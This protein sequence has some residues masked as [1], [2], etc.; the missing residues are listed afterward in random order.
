MIHPVPPTACYAYAMKRIFFLVPVIVIAA[1]GFFVFRSQGSSYETATVT[2]GAI[3]QEV[4]ASGNVASPDTIDL[5][6][7]GSGRL[8]YLPVKVGDHVSAGATLARLDT[9]VM[10]AQRAQAQAAAA[11]QQAQLGS[12]QDGTRPEQLAVTEAQVDSDQTALAQANQAIINAIQNAYTQSDDAVHNKTDQFFSNP[13][14]FNPLVTFSSSNVQL[15]TNVQSERAAAEA[16]LANWQVDLAH[17]SAI[18]PAPAVLEAEANLAA[19]MQLVSDAN[20]LLNSAISNNQQASATTIAGWIASVATA[21]ANVNA[22][23]TTLTSAVTAQKAAAAALDRDKKNLSLEQAGSTE[24][25]LDAQ[26]ALVQQAQASVA[27][28]DA[29][30]GQMQLMAPVG[31]TITAVNVERGE[32]MAPGVVA[33]TMI[34]D[35]T[36]QIDVNLSEDNV[37]FVKIGDTVRITLDALPNRELPGVVT[38]IDPAQTVI[39]GAIYYKTTVMFTTP[40]PLVKPGMTAN[41]WIETGM[42]T[43]TLRVP[44]SAISTTGTSTYVQLL[45][46]GAV[47]KQQVETGLK[48]QDGMIEITAGL[49]EGETVVTGTK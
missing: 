28:I 25:V 5:Q 4:L 12:L 11:A 7:Q 33:I 39:G 17:I 43:S 6:F 22:A 29:Q 21:R 10:E 48:G 32:T 23:I 40:Q 36:L 42:A 19:I 3:T 15:Q 2:R 34:P 47:T 8:V 20:G 9:S 26:E 44:A 14:S 45:D 18:D 31:G 46:G 37:A 1:I 49:S 13:R 16:T 35:A 27:A 38:E 30:I 41:I 24:H